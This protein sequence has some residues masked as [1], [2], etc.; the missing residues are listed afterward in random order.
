MYIVTYYKHHLVENVT[1][2]QLLLLRRAEELSFFKLE[3]YFLINL[4]NVKSPI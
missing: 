3:F 1:K 2:L 4:K